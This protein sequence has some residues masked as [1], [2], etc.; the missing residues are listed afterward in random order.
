LT[1]DHGAWSSTFVTT[2]RAMTQPTLLT[3]L[4]DWSGRYDVIF[5]DVWGVVHNGVS[6]HAVAGAALTA[7][8]KNG[9]VV[10]MISNAPRPSWSVVEQLD[11]FDVVRTAY[12]GVVTSGD[13]TQ[14]LARAQ[15]VGRCF[16]IGAARDEPLFRDLAVQRVPIG[17]A[18]FI[19]CSGLRDDETETAEGYRTELSDAADRRLT[20]ICANPD[21]V[22]ERGHRLIAC[23]GALAE[24][25]EEL[26]GRVIQAGKPHNP[27][28]EAT[29]AKASQV[30]G[31][32]PA[33][34]RILA[35]GDAI[36]TDIAGAQAF[37][38]DSVFLS[39]GIHALELHDKAGALDR[40]KI[41]PF[42]AAQAF[43]PTAV[44]RHLA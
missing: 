41:S 40:E 27:I 25:Y 15:P 9:G 23:A 39:A 37:G 44:M 32:A 29:L 13:V 10:I 24:I 16:H 3:S 43:R 34:N 14:E 33:K 42:L 11:Q 17:E 38:I 19:I 5:S 28:Y 8:R 21:L 4:S 22:V 1:Q 20:M 30:M 36:R 35:I 26:G 7:F 31:R 2:E 6:P 18:S 12:D